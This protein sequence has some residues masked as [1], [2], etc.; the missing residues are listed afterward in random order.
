M[1]HSASFMTAIRYHRHGG[2]E[3]LQLEQAPFPQPQAGEVLVRI[4]HAGVLPVDWKLRQGLMPVPVN[5][6]VIPG[7]AFAGVIAEIGPGVTG[8]RPGQAVFGRSPKGTYAAYTTAAVDAIALKP[9]ALPFAEAASLSG[10]ATTAWQALVHDGALK[11]GDRILIH[12]AAG[13]VGLYA[14]Q[15]ARWIGATVIG[16]ASPANMDFVR[17]LGAAEV[18]DYRTTPFE[19]AAPEVDFVLDTVGGPTLERSWA[20]VKRGGTLVSL[21]AQPS[22]ER[23]SELGIRALKPSRTAGTADLEAIARLIEQGHVRTFIGPVLQL[24][25]AAA[26]HRLSQSGHGRGRIV[27]HVGD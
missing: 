4:H 21:L 14:V 22:A 16:T 9:D 2:P 15:F 25:Q 1:S 7:T 12:G 3:V 8:F 11:A 19:Q 18:V 27:L 26:A 17:S 20:V 5:F 13:G 6:P 23:A 24:A 10:G